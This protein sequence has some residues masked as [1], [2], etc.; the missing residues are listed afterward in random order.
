MFYRY[1]RG[2][3]NELIINMESEAI[4]LVEVLQGER[5]RESD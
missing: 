5:E 1:F 4:K 2:R 3:V